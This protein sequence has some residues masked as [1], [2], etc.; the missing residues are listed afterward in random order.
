MEP[1]TSFAFPKSMH[2]CAR[3]DIDLLFTQG[4]SFVIYPFRVIYL[5]VSGEA[6][7]EPRATTCQVAV[8]VPKRHF[9]RAVRRNLLKRRTR[10][11]YRLHYAALLA[12]ALQARPGVHLNVLFFYLST[13]VLPFN[14]IEPK[15]EEVLQKLA[16]LTA[17]AD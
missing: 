8:S 9:K 10:E 2:L 15:M 4:R 3:R 6:V 5:F 13:E 7:T 16:R 17:K 14:Q 12:P 1:A 11:A